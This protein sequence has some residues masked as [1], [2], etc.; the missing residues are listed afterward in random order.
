MTKINKKYFV[1]ADYI[2]SKNDGDRHFITCN[3]LMR[4]YSV[5]EEE[6]VCLENG[7]ER[8]KMY[9]DRYGNLIELRPKSDGDY[10]LPPKAAK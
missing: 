2:T 3:Q 1:I 6:C 4:L 5:R 8:Y 10:R 7:T 9:V